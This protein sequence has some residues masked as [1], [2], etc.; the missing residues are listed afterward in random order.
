[1]TNGVLRNISNCLPNGVVRSEVQTRLSCHVL[2]LSQ[3]GGLSDC[4]GRARKHCVVLEI[5]G[6]EDDCLN[7]GMEATELIMGH[8]K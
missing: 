7:R 1:M 3:Y 6:R 2:A 5:F 8:M 4:S